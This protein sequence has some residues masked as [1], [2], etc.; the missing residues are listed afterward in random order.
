MIIMYMIMLNVVGIQLAC[1]VSDSEIKL[2]IQFVDHFS[3]NLSEISD[4]FE[5]DVIRFDEKSILLF[6]G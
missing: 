6:Q 3:E 4:I 1:S 5:S 2:R